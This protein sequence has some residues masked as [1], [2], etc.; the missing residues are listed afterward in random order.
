[1]LLNL[2]S[3]KLNRNLFKSVFEVSITGNAIT[4]KHMQSIREEVSKKSK[5]DINEIFVDSSNTPSIPLSPSKKESKSIIILER[6]GVKITAK[7]MPISD[8]RLVSVMSGF[9][10]ILRVYTPVKNRKKV[11]IAA[12]S[13]LNDLKQ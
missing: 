10:K 9:M 6:D 5:V 2:R 1:M 8:I 13:I 11:E 12:K 7:E 4:K 3:P